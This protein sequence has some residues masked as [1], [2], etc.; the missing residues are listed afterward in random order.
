[1]K[2]KKGQN[3]IQN[4]SVE[5]MRKF[6]A[7]LVGNPGA[8]EIHGLKGGIVLNENGADTP[9]KE[10]LQRSKP[11]MTNMEESI[12]EPRIHNRIKHENQAL[13]PWFSY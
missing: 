12:Y 6:R 10:D 9:V 13:I 8:L 4:G 7:E 3:G 11:L 2:E 1:M 5:E